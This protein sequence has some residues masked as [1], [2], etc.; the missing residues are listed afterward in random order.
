MGSD[1]EP[2]PKN[3]WNLWHFVK[4]LTPPNSPLRTLGILSSWKSRL[5]ESDQDAAQLL[6]TLSEKARDKGMPK[7]DEKT[8]DKGKLK[9][10]AA[11]KGCLKVGDGVS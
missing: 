1:T 10:D 3:H 11:T 4:G 2:P 9:N 5:R 6:P 8:R 7:N